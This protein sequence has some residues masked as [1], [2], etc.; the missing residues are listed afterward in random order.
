M[1]AARVHRVGSFLF[2]SGN[3]SRKIRELFP[4]NNFTTCSTPNLG[5]QSA[6]IWTWS[7]I[8]SMSKISK[9]FSSAICVKSSFARF[10]ISSVKTFRLYLGAKYY[11]VLA[12]IYKMGRMLVFFFLLPDNSYSITISLIIYDI[13]YITNSIE[14]QISFF[15]INLNPG[16]VCRFPLHG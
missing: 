16:S 9:S 6:S 2:S 14:C 7:D 11:M 5:L 4:F 12:A 13:Y 8:I 15:L 1:N 10:A 3:S